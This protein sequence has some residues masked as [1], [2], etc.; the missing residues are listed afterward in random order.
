MILHDFK[1][2]RGHVFERMVRWDVEAVACPTCG[3]RA[4]RVFLSWRSHPE[5]AQRFNPIVVFKNPDSTYRFPGR[6]NEPTPSACQRVELRTLSQ[7]RR[8]EREENSRLKSIHQSS[9]AYQEARY[10]SIKREMREEFKKR[11]ESMSPR[12]KRLAE[13]AMRMS[14]QRESHSSRA[15]KY[16]AGFR[17][18]VAHDD[19]SNRFAFR[20][21]DT[22]WQAKRE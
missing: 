9:M 12:G 8:F 18:S 4:A 10:R 22:D 19:A 5:N 16:D 7:V 6:S 3:S 21:V 11:V 1:C 2:A 15:A 20:D 14:D 17:I 13:F